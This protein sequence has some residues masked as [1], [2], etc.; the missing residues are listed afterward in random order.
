[1]PIILSQTNIELSVLPKSK[2]TEVRIIFTIV[3]SVGIKL[4]QR[5]SLS[6]LWSGCC[7]QSLLTQE[8]NL[9]SGIVRV[10]ITAMKQLVILPNYV[11]IGL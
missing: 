8:V 9:T 3:R 4:I 6:G 10:C 5:G 7:R 2:L 1:M 11:H